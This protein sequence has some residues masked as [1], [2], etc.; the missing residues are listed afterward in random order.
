MY[1]R[2]PEKLWNNVMLEIPKLSINDHNNIDNSNPDMLMLKE[3]IS[4]LSNISLGFAGDESSS[5]E[6]SFLSQLTDSV[7]ETAMVKP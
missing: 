3:R 1:S 6:E 7:T 2:K 5:C 4:L